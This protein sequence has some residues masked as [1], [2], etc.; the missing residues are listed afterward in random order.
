MNTVGDG[1]AIAICGGGQHCTFSTSQELTTEEKGGNT[2]EFGYSTPVCE[3]GRDIGL[4]ESRLNSTSCAYI[5]QY[6]RL[7]SS[8]SYGRDLCSDSM[9]RPIEKASRVAIPVRMYATGSLVS[10]LYSQDGVSSAYNWV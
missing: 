7:D 4:P 2:W 8:M 5:I 1:C 10:A 9:L 6:V 3:D